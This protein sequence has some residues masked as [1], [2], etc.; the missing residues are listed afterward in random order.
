V[1]EAVGRRAAYALVEE[2]EEQGRAGALVGKAIG[3]AAAVS[4]QQSVSFEFA[5]VVAQLAK[6][7][8]GG[9]EAEAGK[10]RLMDLG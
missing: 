6:R 10:D 7:I 2:D 8:A 4:L 3:A 1:E 5:Q 9:G